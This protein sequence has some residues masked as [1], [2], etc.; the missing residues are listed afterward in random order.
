MLY[1]Q[2]S[3]IVVPASVMLNDAVA[4]PVIEPSL[5]IVIVSV[6]WSVPASGVQVTL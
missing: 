3:V 4:L 5:L 6:I 1:A 2:D